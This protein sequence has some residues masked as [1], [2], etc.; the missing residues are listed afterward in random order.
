MNPLLLLRMALRALWRAKV[1]SLLTSLGIIV[2]IAAVIAMKGIGDGATVM[3]QNQ[4]S[5]LGD[6]LVMI[7]PGSQ[8]SG[9]V[10]GGM[11]TQQNLMDGDATAIARECVHVRAVCP[12]VMAGAQTMYGANNWRTMAQGVTPSFQEVRRWTVTE[13]TFFTEADQRSGARVCVLGATV[14]QN[15]FGDSMELPENAFI[16]IRNI[17]F[18]VLGILS[19]KGTAAWG[20]DQDDTILTPLTTCRRVLQR[21]PFD[22]VNQVMVSLDSMDNLELARQEI[23]AVLRERHHLAVSADDDFT[24][25]DMT[26]VTKMV[27]SVASSMKILLTIIASISLIVGGI[28]IMNIMLVSVTE[29]TREIGLRMAVGARQRDILNQF[30]VEAILLSGVGGVIGIGFGIGAARILAHAKQWPVLIDPS[31]ILLAL[32]VSAGIGI[33]FGFYPAWRASRLNPIDA[34]RYE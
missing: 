29:R 23:T 11:G 7:F 15:L 4:M 30:L 1:R 20:Q 27:S 18:R 22:N 17:P 2:G 24:I 16:R 34:L 14:A 3:I 32:G 21:N 28:G 25:R 8:N 31:T 19:K 33:F 13:G 10:R 9:G 5:S 6:N 12:I 26:E